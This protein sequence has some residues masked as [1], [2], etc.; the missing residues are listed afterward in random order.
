MVS[1]RLF[2][3]LQVWDGDAAVALPPSRKTRLL[4]AYLAATARPHRRERLCELFWDLPD[5]PRGALRWSLSK[6]RAILDRESAQVVEA[7]RN[8]VSLNLE[9]AQVDLLAVRA[10]LRDGV[11]GAATQILES[12]ATRFRGPFLADLDPTG[13]P[14]LDSWLAAMREETRRLHADI[15]YTLDDRHAAEPERALPY[16]RELVQLDPW[17]EAAWAR[18][19]QRLNAAGRRQEAEA[20]YAAAAKALAEVGGPTRLLE[21]ARQS[22]AAPAASA[23]ALAAAEM[24]QEIRFCRAGDGVR[25]AYALAGEGPPLVKTANWMNHLEYDWE[26]PIFA[27]FLRGLADGRRLLRYDAR[28]NGLSDWDVGEV[29]QDTWYADFEAVIEASGFERFP[30]LGVSQGAASAITYA[31]R[32]PERVSHLVLLGAFA[33]GRRDPEGVAQR[34]AMTTLVRTGWADENPAFRQLFA[35]LFIPGATRELADAFNELQRRTTSAECAARYYE[36]AGQLDVR[37]LLPKVT[38]PTLVL[39]SRGDAMVP[40]EAGRLLASSIPNARFVALP[41]QNHIML[42]DEPAL[43]R[44]F[45]ELRDFLAT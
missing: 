29:N 40:I 33:A 25:I 1:I 24:R 26:S 36:A 27:H 18:L 2:G 10:A 43:A 17:A 13:C 32:H 16:L 19:V 28:G 6:L 34:K 7:D 11:D 45:E 30:I 3:D 38:V 39:H 42:E 22:E 21:R 41:G 14:E 20:Q 5:D 35:S 23:S 44:F 9:P 12:L 15:L 8:E 4:L 31:V 37:E